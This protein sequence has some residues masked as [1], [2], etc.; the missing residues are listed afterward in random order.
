[1]SFGLPFREKSLQKKKVLVIPT[2]QKPHNSNNKAVHCVFTCTQKPQFDFNFDSWANNY[3]HHHK[4]CHLLL[5]NV[6]TLPRLKLQ[7]QKK[8][9]DSPTTTTSSFL[10][11]S[12]SSKSSRK[13]FAK[14]WMFLHPARVRPLGKPLELYSQRMLPSKGSALVRC[15]CVFVFKTLDNLFALIFYLRLRCCAP[16]THR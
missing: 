13:T 8:E 10:L 12:R 9:Q 11:K 2:S 16:V 1:M 15:R 4:K 14:H 7:Q 6:A 3:K 5:P